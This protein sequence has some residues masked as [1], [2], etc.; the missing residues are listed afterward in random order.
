MDNV[1]SVGELDCRTNL[2]KKLEPTSQIHVFALDE[3]R[4]R[5]SFDKLHYEV[6]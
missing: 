2:E 3:L 5:H 4:D 6:R 1:L